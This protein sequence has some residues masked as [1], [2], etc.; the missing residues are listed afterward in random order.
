MQLRA[1]GLQ[2]GFRLCG[3][4]TK[5]FRQRP[6]FVRMVVMAQMRRFMRG[7]II[8]DEGRRQ[9]QP[10]GKIQRAL[11]P[12]RIPTGSTYRARRAQ[13]ARVRSSRRGG[14]PPF[15]DRAAPRA[16]ENRRYAARNGRDRRRRKSL[17][18]VPHFDPD[19]SSAS[20]RSAASGQWRSTCVDAAQGN[21][22]AGRKGRALR[23]PREPVSDPFGMTLVRSPA[24]GADWPC[25]HGQDDVAGRR[26][27][28]QGITRAAEATRLRAM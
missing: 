15:R 25:R 2:P 5:A 10:P 17:G 11:S 13:S 26:A 24:L 16:E 9:N 19:R 1:M 22:C 6:E 14:A 23:Q 27:D 3:L 4:G 7:E 28:P 20:C 21:L 8:E 18:S 12:N